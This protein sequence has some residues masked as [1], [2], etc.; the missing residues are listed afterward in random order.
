MD[1]GWG[2]VSKPR[3]QIP[4]INLQERNISLIPSSGFMGMGYKH[5]NWD[6]NWICMFFG[7]NL[8]YAL[9]QESSACVEHMSDNYVIISSLWQ[10][11]SCGSTWQVIV[12]LFLWL[13][14]LHQLWISN[15]VE[16]SHKMKRIHEGGDGM[17]SRG[18]RVG[19]SRR[20]KLCPQW[21]E[22]IPH[23]QAEKVFC[24]FEHS[25]G[26]QIIS[27]FT[28]ERDHCNVTHWS[29]CVEIF[30]WHI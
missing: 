14:H 20:Q 4:K 3:I 6:F 2:L 25:T 23:H 13:G 27:E 9:L 24:F 5:Y 29:M 30:Y 8:E 1:L 12:C 22:P 17:N 7:H 26:W 10:D 11:R 19:G 16:C 15:S 21:W 28:V 18:V